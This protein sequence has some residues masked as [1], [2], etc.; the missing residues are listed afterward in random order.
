MRCS[1]LAG[2]SDPIQEPNVRVSQPGCVQILACAREQPGEIVDSQHKHARWL[3]IRF[4]K[5]DC[6]RKALLFIVVGLAKPDSRHNAIL[7]TSS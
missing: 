2:A 3:V 7:A 6:S 4:Y 5:G 1:G